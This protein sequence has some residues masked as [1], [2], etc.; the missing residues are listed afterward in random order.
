MGE[1]LPKYPLTINY[2]IG[3]VRLYKILKFNKSNA[4]IYI[5]NL[6]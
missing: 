4:Q 6:Q 1:N 3:T 2:I 5:F